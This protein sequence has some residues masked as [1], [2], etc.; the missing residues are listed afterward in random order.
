MSINPVRA[1]SY[2][3]SD[4]QIKLT[5]DFYNIK[6]NICSLSTVCLSFEILLGAWG[7]RFQET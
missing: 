5:C 6:N 7:G 4:F 2:F 1:K 3:E